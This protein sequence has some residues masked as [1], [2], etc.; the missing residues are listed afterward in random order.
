MTKDVIWI[1][2]VHN[3]LYYNSIT[4]PAVLAECKRSQRFLHLYIIDDLSED[5]T[6]EFIKSLKPK[7]QLPGQV[8]IVRKKVGNS[9]S[10]WNMGIELSEKIGGKYLFNICNDNLF[11]A[12]TLDYMAAILDDS[13]DHFALGCK[14]NA[15]STHHP[16]I[17]DYPYILSQPT[18]TETRHIGCGLVRIEHMKMKGPV[19][20]G[21]AP[22]ESRYFG[23]TD[24]Q[25]KMAL[26]YGKKALLAQHIRLLRLDEHPAYSRL[27]EYTVKG[28]G[29]N[30]RGEVDSVFNAK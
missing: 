13:P 5:G 16:F 3:R 17:T 19:T 18:V 22:G 20:P 23:F 8:T 24:Y 9:T 29:R 4:F 21:Q 30:I 27:E 7:K 12:K 28:Y 10:Q 2:P 1:Y 15:Y 26:E 6:T 11:A 14:M 25:H